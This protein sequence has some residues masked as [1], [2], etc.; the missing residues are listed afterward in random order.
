MCAGML[1]MLHNNVFE[2]I[3][4][5]VQSV[6]TRITKSITI[7]LPDNMCRKIMSVK[8]WSI[9]ETLS[10]IFTEINLEFK[11][12][13]SISFALLI[14]KSKISLSCQS[15]ATSS[16]YIANYIRRRFKGRKKNCSW[17][18]ERFYMQNQSAK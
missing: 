11:D 4:S 8:R 16:H 17:Y 14:S 10:K 2:T 6:C 13:S 9:I 3:D 7:L 1:T 18:H 12:F 15:T 5:D